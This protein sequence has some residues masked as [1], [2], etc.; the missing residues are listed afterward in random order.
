MDP[1]PRP[2][3]LPCL[4]RLNVSAMDTPTD[5]CDVNPEPPSTVFSTDDLRNHI[6]TFLVHNET[7]FRDVCRNLASWR[8]TCKDMRDQNDQHFY[9]AAFEAVFLGGPADPQRV[10]THDWVRFFRDMCNGCAEEIDYINKNPL[11]YQQRSLSDF[12]R[13][14]PF[15]QLTTLSD[16]DVIHLEYFLRMAEGI[17]GV[18]EQGNHLYVPSYK[19][20]PFLRRYASMRK[21]P[22]R[23]P[24]DYAI[25]DGLLRQTLRN[26][27]LSYSEVASSIRDQF[28]ADI[29]P[30][31]NN[32]WDNGKSPS[33]E[34]LMER[35]LLTG[36]PVGPEALEVLTILLDNGASQYEYRSSDSLTLLE[37]VI[38]RI[39]NSKALRGTEGYDEY[40]AIVRLLL[41]PKLDSSDKAFKRTDLK[42]ET[43]FSTAYGWSTRSSPLHI[44]VDGRD[45]VLVRM[46]LEA[47]ADIT[48]LDSNGDTVAT[49]V[50]REWN[51]NGNGDSMLN[52]L[53]LL[54][55]YKLPEDNTKSI[56]DVPNKNGENVLMV[57]AGSKDPHVLKTMIDRLK[58]GR[59]AQ[60]EDEDGHNVLF[61]LISDMNDKEEHHS[62]L[63]EVEKCLVLL[64]DAGA[65]VTPE[66]IDLAKKERWEAGVSRLEEAYRNR[67]PSSEDEEEPEPY[68]PFS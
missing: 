40:M 12:P 34:V 53:E 65:E 16:R 10:Q 66:I 35:W 19:P 51:V 6:R 2:G 47:G 68:D 44:A 45:D 60:E 31:P 5:E 50:V 9:Q 1:P 24:Y 64:L 8:C 21:F 38:Y 43:F 67:A 32:Y 13:G 7:N 33:I 55:H 41:T 62:T 25:A 22:N 54:E 4:N 14:F 17:N 57:A 46:L 36:A 26:E 3:K 20:T 28:A 29:K 37:Q 42:Y 23:R 61:H 15:E 11:A 59:M 39:V 27:N 48:A 18:Q 56:L 63:E 30:S 49:S 52:M 58:L